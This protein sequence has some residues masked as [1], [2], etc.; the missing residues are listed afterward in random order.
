[1]R[2][3]E[4]GQLINGDVTIE[5]LRGILRLRQTEAGS[6]LAARAE[7]LTYED[8]GDAGQPLR[9]TTALRVHDGVAIEGDGL[10]TI[11]LEAVERAATTVVR[12]APDLFPVGFRALHE[13]I[14]QA[15]D[16]ATSF[17]RELYIDC[18]GLRDT[19]VTELQTV[20]EPQ[21]PLTPRS[22]PA[23]QI[24]PGLRLVRPRLPDDVAER[25]PGQ[26]QRRLIGHEPRSSLGEYKRVA[27][28]VRG[29]QHIGEVP[30]G[31]IT[32]K[33]LDVGDV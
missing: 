16:H 21:L 3:S 4:V 32:R 11:Q 27:A 30:L 7:Q 14:D 25:L 8:T 10:T 2:L 29:E 28:D 24:W 1:M 5:Q 19:W 33:G 31:A 22:V 9:L 13:W 18:D 6:R 12:G 20:L 17:E 23:G 15:G 26:V